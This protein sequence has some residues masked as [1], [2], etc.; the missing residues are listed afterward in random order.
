MIIRDFQLADRSEAWALLAGQAGVSESDLDQLVAKARCVVARE[1]GTLLGFASLLPGRPGAFSL[2]I[3]VAPERR[4]QGVGRQ[5]WQ[6]L[7]SGLPAG[8]LVSGC[9]PITADETVAFLTEVGFQPWFSTELMHYQGPAFP[10]PGLTARPYQDEDFADWVRLLNR[11]FHPLRQALDIQPYNVFTEE[12]I[13]DPATRERLLHSED[14]DDLLF[15]DGDRLVGLAEL[16]GAEIDT[17]TVA[18][19]LRRQGYGR[20]IMAFCANRLLAR[21]HCPVS[22]HVVSWNAGARRLYASMGWQFIER[23]DFIRWHAPQPDR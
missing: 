22:L 14:D 12:Q 17:V 13:S 7:C 9:C 18:P 5:L 10:D 20:R 8:S 2:R 1:A 23:S 16:A 19:E 21:G 15:F 6:A 11:G 4:R 3:F